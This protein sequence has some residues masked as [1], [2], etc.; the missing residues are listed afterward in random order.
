MRLRLLLPVILLG[1]LSFT[2]DTFDTIV[3][4]I[5]Q[6]NAKQVV[7]YF[8]NSVDMT[9]LENEAPYGRSQAE[10]L[11]RDFFTKNPP[12]SFQIIHRG[13]SQEGTEFGIGNLISSNG[14]EFRVSFYL[15][16][17]DGKMTIREFRIEAD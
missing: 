15:K 2:P 8:G 11:L 10:F 17:Q 14:K 13:R 16:N 9:L 3:S 5:Q 12:K 1:L 7:T 4:S 6:A